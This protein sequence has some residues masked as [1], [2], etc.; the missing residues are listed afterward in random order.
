MGKKYVG[1]GCGAYKDQC[2][3]TR[4]AHRPRDNGVWPPIRN[5][6]RILHLDQNLHHP[7]ILKMTSTPVKIE[8]DI[9]KA[10]IYHIDNPYAPLRQIAR[11]FAVPKYWLRR[12]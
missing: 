2:P 9:Q 8:E 11:E 3:D 6:S 1:M 12:R 4:P 7:H 5:R 10:L